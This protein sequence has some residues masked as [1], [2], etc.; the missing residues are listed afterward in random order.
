MEALF[1]VVV[2]LVLVILAMKALGYSRHPRPVADAKEHGS[3]AVETGRLRE[4]N[5]QLRAVVGRME[6][7]MAVLE[8]IVTDKGYTVAEEIEALRDQPLP[9]D[10][11]SGVPLNL[12]KKERA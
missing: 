8:R 5:E 3:N 7:R 9:R 10:N 2:T 4:Q 12:E 6:D 1:F 11:D